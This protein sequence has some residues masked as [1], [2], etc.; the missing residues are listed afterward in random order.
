MFVKNSFEYDAR[1]TKEAKSLVGAGHDVTVVAIHVPQKTAEHEVTKDGIRVIRVSRMSFGMRLA[2]RTHARYVVGVEERHARLSGTEIDEERVRKYTAVLPASTATPGDNDVAVV[3]R[4]VHPSAG[5][6]PASGLTALWARAS[7]AALRA[8][9]ATARWAFRAARFLLIWPLRAARVYR[10]NRRFIAAGLETGADVWH[11][12]DLNTLYVGSRCKAK[13]PGTR[14]VYD[15]HELATQRSRMGRVRRW[16]ASWNERRGLRHVDEVIMTT[17]SRARYQV[18]RYGIPFP[19]LIRNVPEII[20]IEAGW[21]L[22]ERL[23]I[24]PDRRILLYQGS[25]QEYRG[26]E[27]A[28][29][30]VTMLERCVLVVIGY[31]YYRPALEELVRRRGLTDTVKFF[32]PIPNDELLYYTASADVGLCVIRGES[33]SYRWSLPNKLF[34]YMMAGIPVVASDYEEMGR[35]VKE[36][37]VGAVCDPGDPES[38]AAA[39]RAIVDDPEAEARFR[40]ATRSAITRYNWGVE[41]QVLRSI[42]DRYQA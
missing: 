35:V 38:I 30:A 32:G 21:D 34:E 24:P 31:G 19:S 40:A 3:T 39:V 1:V 18:E 2:Q 36:E 8:G 23:E 33:L 12:H 17:R 22:H 14:L 9:S 28:I 37:G 26:I 27:E 6:A 7:T 16:W 4:R 25:I 10:L 11:S 42:Y 29:E 13:R 15:S 5:C 20:E 41:E